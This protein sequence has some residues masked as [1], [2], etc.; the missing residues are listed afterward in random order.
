MSRRA[1][2]RGTREGWIDRELQAE[3]P[4]LALVTL[5]LPGRRA[6][7]PAAVRERLALLSDRFRGAV[8]LT[9]RQAPVPAAIACSRVTSGSIPT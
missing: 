6:R 2:E 7:S 3:F 1:A 9:L 5:E 8:A 4:A